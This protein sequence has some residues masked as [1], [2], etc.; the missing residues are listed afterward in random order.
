MRVRWLAK[1]GLSEIRHLIHTLRNGT[2]GTAAQ[3]GLQRAK[4]L[5]AYAKAETDEAVSRDDKDR[6]ER[7]V[8]LLHLV[9]THIENLNPDDRSWME[10]RVA[11]DLNACYAV[12]ANDVDAA[13]VSNLPFAFVCS[14][15]RSG[16]TLATR[17]AAQLFHAQIFEGNPGSL[18]P[19]DKRL[20]PKIY[21]YIR[22]VKDHVARPIYKN[23]RVAFIVRDGRDC[24]ISLAYM[25]H[26]SGGHPFTKR[27]QLT[28]FIRWLDR[29]YPFGGW[30]RH[31]RDVTALKSDPNKHVVRYEDL[32][33]EFETFRE[34]IQF[35]AQGQ[36]ISEQRIKRTFDN[37]GRIRETVEN[38]PRANKSW[39]YG[40]SFEPDSLFFDW[41]TQ[42]TKSS[43]RQSWDAEA[44]KAFH[45]TGA[46]EHLIAFGYETDPHW[47][48][49][50]L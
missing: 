31:M 21:P 47:W 50:G 16:N 22:L 44:R 26:K 24:M 23:D 19:F 28:D 15:P 35:I 32:I 6:L 12:G 29:D 9:L 39:G 48:K 30:A 46:T 38:N 49:P 27:G 45:E 43:W 3:V 41:S 14:Y 13:V 37:K 18:Q 25:T 10:H 36:T 1:R 17:T 33:A 7:C 20:Y 11:H 40:A 34:Y 2:G 4:R 5:Y 42:R 8:G